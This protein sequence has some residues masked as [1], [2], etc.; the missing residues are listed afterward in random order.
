MI[1]QQ[2]LSPNDQDQESDSF[3]S[4]PKMVSY[5]TPPFSRFRKYFPTSLEN[6]GSTYIEIVSPTVFIQESQWLLWIARNW[7]GVQIV[8]EFG[9]LK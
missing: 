7:G 9:F 2:A 4:S 6:P 3:A 8:G 5:K 1:T